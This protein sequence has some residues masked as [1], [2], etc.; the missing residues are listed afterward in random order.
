MRTVCV[1]KVGADILNNYLIALNEYD[2]TGALEKAEDEEEQSTS[3]AQGRINEIEQI[4][5]LEQENAENSFEMALK[6]YD[7]Y[8]RN[9]KIHNE[10]KKVI[11]NLEK[12]RDKLIKIREPSD[13]LPG[14]FIN[15]TTDKCT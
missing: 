6:L 15:V 9:L 8:K 7:G 12:Y 1:A 10:Y 5:R 11:E 2:Y 4:I 3:S 14:K 13:F